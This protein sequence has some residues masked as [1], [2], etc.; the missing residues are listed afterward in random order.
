ME[1]YR[2]Q[3]RDEIIER[4]EC[5]I[6]E[7][8][9]IAGDQLPSERKL[10][11]LWDCNRMTFRSAVNHLIA[12]GV[13]YSA[14][15]KGNFVSQKK[16]ERYL[17][18]LTSFSDFVM[19]QGRTMKNKIVSQCIIAASQKIADRL[20]INEGDKVFELVRLRIVDDEPVSIEWSHL[21][22]ERF[23]G[24]E[25]YD[26]KRLSLYSVL[27][28]KYL[29]AFEGGKEE[30]SVTYADQQE[31]VLLEI[32]EGNPLF[33][34]QGVTWDEEKIPVEYIKSVSRS[35]KINFAGVLVR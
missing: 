11:E 14:P 18:D 8:D 29:V 30:I 22:Y 24:I 17:Q 20:Q 3:P 7:N 4:I 2:S 33:F 6:I 13:L 5:Y 34:L 12:E 31:A 15:S 32:A 10:C 28:M 9:L 16:L 21:P 26:F 25:R 19:L 35:D 27:E 23:N 1:P